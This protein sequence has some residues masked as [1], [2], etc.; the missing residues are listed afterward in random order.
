M[1][2]SFSE[3]KECSDV[4]SAATYCEVVVKYPNQKSNPKLQDTMKRAFQERIEIETVG[5][6]DY[7]KI[8][9]KDPKKI[10]GF[11]PLQI[12]VLLLISLG[13]ILLSY[14]FLH[15]SNLPYLHFVSC[16]KA[17]FMNK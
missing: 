3:I 14:V 7:I 1:L 2:N 11:T 4:F 16:L 8:F 13:F 15:L 9:F 5:G 10:I 12:I 17:R 6:R